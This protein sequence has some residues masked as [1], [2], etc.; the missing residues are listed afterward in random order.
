MGMSPFRNGA[1]GELLGE[2]HAEGTR[3]VGYET[4]QKGIL[5]ALTPE[6]A[7]YIGIEGRRMKD[8]FMQV[9]HN[10]PPAYYRDL[11]DAVRTGDMDLLR[12]LQ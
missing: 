7:D 2:V 6:A 9:L 10:D 4:A 8:I 3:R 1:L 11:Y 12:I 5:G